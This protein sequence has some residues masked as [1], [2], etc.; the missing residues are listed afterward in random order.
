MNS[1]DYEN[2]SY[3]CINT[4]FICEITR[5]NYRKYGRIEDLNTSIMHTLLQRNFYFLQH[6]DEKFELCQWSIF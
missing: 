1:E 5:L 3:P 2:H 6:D 4:A